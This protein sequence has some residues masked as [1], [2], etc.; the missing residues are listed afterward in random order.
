MQWIK[1]QPEELRN[2]AGGRVSEA[3]AETDPQAAT[4]F[5]AAAE[6]PGAEPILQNSFSKWLATDSAAAIAW[7]AA[8]PNKKEIDPLLNEVATMPTQTNGQVKTALSW[9]E[10]I[11]DTELRLNAVTSILSA[12]KQKDSAAAE[13][14]LQDVTYLTNEQRTRL[15]DDL[16]FDK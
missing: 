8:S 13:V 1:T 6:I 3:W 11:Q 2:S 12:F 15:V 7:L 10:R 16:A 4:H 5:A 14:Y 9:A